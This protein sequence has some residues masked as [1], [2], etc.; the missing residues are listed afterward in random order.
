MS[1][2]YGEMTFTFHDNLKREAVEENLKT[3][4]SCA[5]QGSAANVEDSK[6]FP[7][8][9]LYI[10]TVKLLEE[11]GINHNP[12]PHFQIRVAQDN[13]PGSP[14]QGSIRF[15]KIDDKILYLEGMKYPEK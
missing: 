10:Q 6:E 3:I 15:R 9:D 7:A 14:M 4:I 8:K 11:M 2:F 1:T 12:G 13:F 5:E